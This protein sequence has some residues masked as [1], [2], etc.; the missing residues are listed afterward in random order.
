MPIALA[1]HLSVERVDNSVINAL[2]P[3]SMLDI[4]LGA[5]PNIANALR[6]VGKNYYG[7]WSSWP[8]KLKGHLA[9]RWEHM[10]D[11]YGTGMPAPAP[12][13]FPDP[14]PVAPV[15][16]TGYGSFV[17]TMEHGRHVYLSHVAN[18]LALEMTGK[19][20]W[21]IADY[22][23]DEAK[24]LLSSWM[25]LQYVEPPEAAVEG[26]YFE[27]LNSPMTPGHVMRFLTSNDLLGT[28]ALD[29][30]ARFFG[31]CR[32]LTHYFTEDD[33]PPDIHAFWG[34]DV[35]PIP[36]SMVIKGTNYT[37][38]DPPR[39]GHYTYGCAGTAALMRS[40]L[41]VVNIPVAIVVPPC[42]H[43]M[44]QF[45]SIDRAMSH[46]DD[47][48]DSIATF[49]DVPGWPRPTLDEYLITMDQYNDWFGASIDPNVSINNVARR[50]AELAVQYVSD[51]LLD[52]YCDDTAAGLDH[53]GGQVYDVLKR[54]YTVA[55]LESQQ[56]WDRLAQKAQAANWCGTAG[57]RSPRP[58]RAVPTR[59]ATEPVLALNKHVHAKA[60]R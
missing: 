32:I 19:L 60:K 4:W 59:R 48:Y 13:P 38:S 26:Y 2:S 53:A 51:Y 43:T 37:G 46:G 36:T 50:P 40:V 12:K 3:E 10:V 22:S 42:G 25:W 28:T 1:S 5:H 23:D 34:P 14:I 57:A 15:A 39:F 49:T 58:S 17:M 21:S 20:P 18:T 11:W 44:A 30:V 33:N 56:L 47:P 35:P 45:P 55:D 9:D 27:E 8:K 7:A 54:H 16:N 24:Q 52:R 41:R 31:W 29:T 6:Y